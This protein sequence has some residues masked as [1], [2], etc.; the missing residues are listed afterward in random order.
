METEIWKVIPNYENYQVSNLGNI[1]SLS[2]EVKNRWNT[3]VVKETLMNPVLRTDGYYSINLRKQTKPKSFLIHQLVA[4][5]FLN[6]KPNGLE[7]VVNHKN[8]IKTDNRLENLEIIT[9]RENCNQKHIKSS[10]KYTG[11]TWNKQRCKWQS[12]IIINGKCKYL[13]LF[14]NEYDASKKY[15]EELKNI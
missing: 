15:L 12:Q 4:I 2:R 6:H 7:L 14:L 8:F 5:C 11:V 10:S 1:K 13:G 3:R 9:A